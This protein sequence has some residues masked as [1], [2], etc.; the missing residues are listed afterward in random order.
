MQRQ[1]RTRTENE[2]DDDNNELGFEVLYSDKEFDE[3]LDS[4]EDGN[5]GNNTLALAPCDIRRPN[6]EFGMVFVCRDDF[7][8]VVQN[9]VIHQKREVKFTKK[10]QDKSIWKVQWWKL[11]REDS[12]FEDIIRKFPTKFVPPKTQMRPKV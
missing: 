10:W 6:F 4:S 9:H 2:D 7:K 5:D 12:C 11:W 8:N 3:F 1:R